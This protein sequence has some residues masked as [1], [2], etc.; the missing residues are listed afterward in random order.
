MRLIDYVILSV[1]ILLLSDILNAAEPS[2][3]DFKAAGMFGYRRSDVTEAAREKRNKVDS[4]AIM[5]NFARNLEKDQL[6]AAKDIDD[7]IFNLINLAVN[8]LN[9]QGHYAIAGDIEV[10]YL[11]HYRGA[12]TAQVLGV[13]EIGDH[14]PLSEWLVKVHDK[15]HDAIGDFLCKYFRFHDIFILNYG[16]PVVFNPK[17]YKLND[18]KD[19]FAGHHIWGWFWEH[20]GVAGVVTYWLVNGVC[21]GSTYGLGIVTFICG[22]I[23]SLSENVMDKRIAPPIAE[24]IWKRAQ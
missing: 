12:V 7:A 16:L 21:I 19:H 22:P 1:I 4:E 9:V 6:A 8:V 11:L 20:H 18:Y 23:A 3:D 13:K 5:K 15:I 24:R 10:E 2:K 14:P 17:Q